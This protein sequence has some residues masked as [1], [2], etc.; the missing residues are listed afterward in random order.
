MDESEDRM[1]V[2]HAGACKPHNALDL[3]PHFRSVAM[4]PAIGTG[5]L[6]LPEWTSIE[7]L[8]SIYF[9]SFTLGA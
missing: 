7:A 6:F 8:V 3:V 2:D 5:R 1:L 9:K 4:N